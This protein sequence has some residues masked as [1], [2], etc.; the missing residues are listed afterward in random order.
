VG[1]VLELDDGGQLNC[2]E[3]PPAPQAVITL[4]AA[5]VSR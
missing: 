5:S 4:T 1:T 2:A 3:A